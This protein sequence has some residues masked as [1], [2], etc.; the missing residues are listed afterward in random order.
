[1]SQGIKHINLLPFKAGMIAR[2][3][4]VSA[5]GPTGAS[6]VLGAPV[7][8]RS[9][10]SDQGEFGR[11][12]INADPALSSVRR[13]QQGSSLACIFAKAQHFTAD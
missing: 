2:G 5:V 13:S 10:E 1:M 7:P 9:D 4:A 6:Q 12:R 11:Y 8:F 3:L